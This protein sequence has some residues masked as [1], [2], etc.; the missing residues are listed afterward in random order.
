VFGWVC[1]CWCMGED[2]CLRT[3]SLTYPVR[4]MQAPYCLQPLAPPYFSTLSHKWHTFWKKLTARSL[5][6]LIFSTTSIFLNISH[7][8]KNPAR[9]CHECINIFMQSSH[10]CC[11]ILTKLE[12]SCQIFEKD[13]NIK[14]HQNP[15]RGS[16]VVPC[17]QTD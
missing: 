17:G 8:K 4:H 15:S 6:V 9:Y 11:W 16:R 2:V 3:T 13:S 5:S 14:S 1:G 7:F 12:F 10:Y